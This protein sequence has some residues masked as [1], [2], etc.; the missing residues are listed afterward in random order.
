MNITKKIQ[1]HRCREQTSD[2]QWG[3]GS[4]E[5][6]DGVVHKEV[7]TIMYKINKLQ[8]REYSQYFLVTINRINL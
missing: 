2:Q 4:W 3:E 7:Q 8:H 1:P 5:G 6:Q